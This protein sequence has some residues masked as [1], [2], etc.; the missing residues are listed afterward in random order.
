MF[1]KMK[2]Q[3]KENPEKTKKIGIAIGAVVGLSAVG[4]LI[5]V[6]RA[7]LE[8]PFFNDINVEIPPAE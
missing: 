7:N 1:E 8:M 4:V 2:N 5:Y 3:I 6:N